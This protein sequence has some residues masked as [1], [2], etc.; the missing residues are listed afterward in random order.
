VRGY[1]VYGE[2]YDRRYEQHHSDA[3][4]ALLSPAPIERD[5][6]AFTELYARATPGWQRTLDGPAPSTN[7]PRELVVLRLVS[8]ADLA[9][10][11]YS[12]GKNALGFSVLHVAKGGSYPTAQI[13]KATFFAN[14]GSASFANLKTITLPRQQRLH[15]HDPTNPIEELFDW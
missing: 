4:R 1:A 14:T 9:S 5:Y 11:T 3:T 8:N 7:V 12:D 10:Q 13:N 2:D 6:V 15:P